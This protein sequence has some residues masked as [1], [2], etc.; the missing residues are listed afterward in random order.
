MNRCAPILL[1]FAL[2]C[3]GTTAAGGKADQA[4]TIAKQLRAAK[5]DDAEKILAEHGMTADQWEA[6]MFE[7]AEDPALAAKYEAELAK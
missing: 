5:P 2:A 4:V 1:S 3:G 7:I 6:L